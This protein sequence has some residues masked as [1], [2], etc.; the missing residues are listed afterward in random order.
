MIDKEEICRKIDG[1]ELAMID[2]WKKLVNR[3]CGPDCKE[4]S[5]Q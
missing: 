2:T 5:M 3:D 1:M 4:G